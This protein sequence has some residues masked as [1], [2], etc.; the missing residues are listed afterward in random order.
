MHVEEKTPTVHEIVK[1]A[2]CTDR[3]KSTQ[4]LDGSSFCQRG[5]GFLYHPGIAG[6]QMANSDVF[7]ELL[8]YQFT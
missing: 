1:N 3:R 2:R 7:L 8:R 6:I 5:L 4:V